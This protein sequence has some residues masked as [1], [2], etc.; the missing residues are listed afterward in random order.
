MNAFHDVNVAEKYGLHKS[1]VFKWK[2]EFKSIEDAV[3]HNH[4]N[5]QPQETFEKRKTVHKA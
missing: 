3:A 5:S 1:I 4:K 2:K